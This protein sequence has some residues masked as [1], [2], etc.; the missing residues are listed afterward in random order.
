MPTKT[1]APKKTDA[2]KAAAKKAA[3][4]KKVMKP[5]GHRILQTAAGV[6]RQIP[7]GAAEAGKKRA[8]KAIEAGKTRA[9]AGHVTMTNASGTPHHIHKIH[10]AR[11]QKKAAAARV[12]SQRI[13]GQCQPTKAGTPRAPTKITTKAGE[14]KTA[15]RAVKGAHGIG[16]SKVVKRVSTTKDGKTVIGKTYDVKKRQTKYTAMGFPKGAVGSRGNVMSGRAHHTAGGLT[17]ANFVK[18]AAGTYVAKRA[19]AAAK[20]RFQD[21]EFAHVAEKFKATRI[22]RGTEK[23]T[24]TA[25]KKAAAKKIAAAMN[26]EELLAV[27]AATPMTTRAKR[28]PKG[29]QKNKATGE[30]K[31]T[32]RSMTQFQSK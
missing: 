29:S 30:C 20:A 10:V 17:A 25:T 21:P 28:C 31:R 19:S 2:Q 22:A 12:K 3:A 11:H 15:C 14:I 13:H 4:A 7:A 9:P 5:T 1:R 8:A 24:K 6:A 27:A 16:H 26:T 32:T 18:S 23:K